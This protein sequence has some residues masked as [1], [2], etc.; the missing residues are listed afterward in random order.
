MS[1]ACLFV[2]RQRRGRQRLGRLAGCLRRSFRLLLFFGSARFLQVG[3]EGILQSSAAAFLDQL[4]RRA[5]G[6]HPPPMH[7]RN[8]VAAFGLVHEMGRQEDGDPIIA[9]KIDQ[10]APEGVAGDRI[11]AR[12]GFVENEHGRPVEHGHRQLQPLLD[13][14]RQALRLGVG[15]SFQIV[16]FEQLVDPGFDLVRRQMVELGMQIE[17]LP[18][19]KLAVEGER[20]RH[21]A[22]VLAR[23]HVVGAHRL[24]EQFGRAFGDRQQSGHH[25]HGCRF[26]AAVRAEEAENLAAADA[27]A[28]M[29][30]GDEIAE[31]ARK[32]IRLDRR[33]LV[34]ALGA[35]PHDDL[36]MLAA[37]FRWKQ[38]NE[39]VVERRL[40]RFGEDLLRCAMRD[41]FA[42]VHGG[43]PIEPARLVHVGGRD[44]HAH[45]RPTR[46]DRIDQLPE[47]P[48][49]ERIDARGGLVENKQIRIVHQRAA[50]ADFLLHAARELAAWS[51]RKRVEPGGF[52]ELV[53]ALAPLGCALPEQ[54]TEEVDVVEDAERRIEIAAKPLR[55]VGD[56]AVA[57]PAMALV[58]HVAVEHHDLAGLNLAHP[59]DEGEQGG[60][61]DAVGPDHPHHAV[62]RN[63]EGQV[64]ERE[65]LSVAMGYA[66]DPVATM[67]LLIT[68]ASPQ[69]RQ[70]REPLGSVRTKPEPAH[71]CFHLAMV[72]IEDFGIALEL[73]PEHQLL[74]LLG[75][76]DALWRELGLG[77]H[78]ADGRGEHVLGNGIEDRAC[79]VP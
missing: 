3:D 56:A 5:D 32:P 67:P 11:D 14:E 54:A 35:R 12:G 55:H 78:E 34:I 10:R 64:V 53:D 46:A 62:G 38:R 73:D 28:H 16:A 9:G 44:N 36:L 25:F 8:A 65:R 59:G 47:L 42:V 29:V 40:L 58:R 27:K 6:E 20:L 71:P 33:R 57:R 41:D 1:G 50:E 72:F 77:R 48:A 49:R 75:G 74:S 69:V 66:L 2:G 79:L 52:Q 13:A 4:L 31:P 30:D 22:D 15:H 26:S 23:L 63:I 17:I 21:V 68:E 43:E 18:H 76:L 37:L 7:Q 70:A 45:L 60:L 61:A 24:A 39:G 19:R 51:I